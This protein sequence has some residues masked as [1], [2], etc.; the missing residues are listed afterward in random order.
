MRNAPLFFFCVCVC[1]CVCVRACVCVYDFDSENETN[2]AYSNCSVRGDPEKK[3]ITPTT[4]FK[5][6]IESFGTLGGIEREKRRVFFLDRKERAV[7]D[8][9]S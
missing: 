1:V 3:T 5:V 4:S 6:P 8:F 9:I 7:F 2:T